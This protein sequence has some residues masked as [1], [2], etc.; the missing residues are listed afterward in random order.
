MDTV[1]RGIIDL[2]EVESVNLGISSSQ[3]L[4]SNV[5]QISSTKKALNNL[6]ISTNLT[7][8]DS[9]DSKSCFELKTSKRVYCFCAKSP[10]EAYKWIK[11]LEICCLDS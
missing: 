9:N 5:P 4:H 1:V 2:S 10:Q 6:I 3:I 8:L 7:G 11:Q